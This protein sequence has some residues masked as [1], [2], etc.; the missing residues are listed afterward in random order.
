MQVDHYQ[1]LQCLMLLSGSKCC[2]S[3][4]D[5]T[6]FTFFCDLFN[7]ILYAEATYKYSVAELVLELQTR[8]SSAIETKSFETDI[9]EAVVSIVVFIFVF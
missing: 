6:H 3:G 2:V 4:N 9:L 7:F 8:I 5:Y 1:Q